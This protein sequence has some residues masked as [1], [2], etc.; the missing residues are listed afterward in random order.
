MRLKMLKENKKI[1]E[2]LPYLVKRHSSNKNIDK[3]A[4]L[5]VQEGDGKE[6]VP[7]KPMI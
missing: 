2:T 3:L 1:Q 5:M 4:K 6:A 7:K